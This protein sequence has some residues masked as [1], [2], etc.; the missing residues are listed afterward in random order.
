M[1]KK[2][3][4]LFLL[5]IL[6]ISLLSVPAAFAVQAR[7]S[8]VMHIS[9]GL[10][11]NGSTLICSGSGSAMSNTDLVYV[12]ISLLRRSHDGGN[13]SFVTSWGSNGVGHLGAAIETYPT[14]ESGYDYYVH[15]VVQIRD[16]E[17]NQLLESVGLDSHILS[18]PAT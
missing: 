15:S 10:D 11:R 17:T 4:A 7:F 9:A 2:Y 14:V 5:S 3:Y 13:W 12:H 6:L 1:K 8:H 16:P 18:Y